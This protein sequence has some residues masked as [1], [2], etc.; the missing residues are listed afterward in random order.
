VIRRINLIPLIAFLLSLILYLTSPAISQEPTSYKSADIRVL[1]FAPK[2][3]GKGI[4]ES[5][6]LS[7]PI[8]KIFK[9]G[10]LTTPTMKE[11]FI[12][13]KEKPTVVI[14]PLGMTSSIR[15]NLELVYAEDILREFGS[16]KE[17]TYKSDTDKEMISAC[18][19]DGKQLCFPLFAHTYFPTAG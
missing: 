19:Q 10:F 14:A 16:I 12:A 2:D 17:A 6:N 8:F 4:E 11:F 5:L 13:I 18:T 7:S 15:S 3:I 1:I 9:P